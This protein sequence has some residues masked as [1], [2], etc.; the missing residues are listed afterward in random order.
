VNEGI[1]I[2][3]RDYQ[4]LRARGEAHQLVDVREP[5]E[6]RIARFEDAVLIPLRTL[7][8]RLQEL[9]RDRL[10]VLHC[11]IGARS[12][13]ALEYLKAQGFT[14]LKNLRGGI[15]AWSREVDPAVPRY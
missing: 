1:E 5:H 14:R 9:D 8:E 7:P 6:H 2:T 4:A 13:A 12:M 11:H 10:I 15:D 3:V